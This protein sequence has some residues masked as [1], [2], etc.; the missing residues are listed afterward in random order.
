ML[1]LGTGPWAQ[2]Y[3]SLFHQ[4]TESSK[5]T[6]GFIMDP[7]FN[8]YLAAVAGMHDIYGELPCD[9]ASEFHVESLAA[10]SIGEEALT[11][12]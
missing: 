4:A 6:E 9:T 3:Q 1:F 12:C 11:G 5:T 8:E 7:H 10:E 2:S